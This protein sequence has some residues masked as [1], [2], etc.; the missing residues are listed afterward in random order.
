MTIISENKHFF[1]KDVNNKWKIRPSMMTKKF[2]ITTMLTLLFID[3]D[4]PTNHDQL[5][6]Q[7]AP[8]ASKQPCH[9]WEQSHRSHVLHMN[10]H[11]HQFLCQQCQ[12]QCQMGGSSYFNATTSIFSF[13][14]CATHYCDP[15]AKAV[16]CMYTGLYF[17][18][19]KSAKNANVFNNCT[20][21]PIH[22]DP[23]DPRYMVV[24]Q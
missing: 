3:H 23:C 14:W 10:H 24:S 17:G 9:F 1:G 15:L 7:T 18:L 4:M 16:V 5:T 19:A 13:F 22:Q 20:L 6:Q 21:G 12:Q 8:F 11:N 2:N